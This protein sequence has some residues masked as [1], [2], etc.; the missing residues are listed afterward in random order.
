ME[1]LPSSPNL[2]SSGQV[3]RKLTPCLPI[4]RMTTIGTVK[5]EASTVLLVEVGCAVLLALVAHGAEPGRGGWP[6]CV[7]RLS[8]ADDPVK[9]ASRQPGRKVN[10]PQ[11]RFIAHKAHHCRNRSE[12]V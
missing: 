2:H 8:A 6:W 12:Y 1:R 9:C 3:S 10:R 4:Q 5:M 7:A 11:R